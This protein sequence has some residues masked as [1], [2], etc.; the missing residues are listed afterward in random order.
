[1]LSCR[2]AD[3]RR[4]VASGVVSAFKK[5]YGDSWGPRLEHIL[6]NA[7]LAL[8]EVPGTSLLSLQ[9]LLGDTQYRKDL[10]GT[11][12]R[13]GG[14]HLLGEGVRHL[15]APVPGR[16]HRPDPEQGR[17]VP[18]PSRSSGRS[19]GSR[20][21]SLDLRRVMDEGQILIVNLSKGRIG[22]DGST[23][24][25]SLLVTGIQLAAMSRADVPENAAPRLR[26]L[27]G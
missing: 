8:L 7:L 2:E 1:M 21:S 19:S 24:L 9:R 23:L 4:L 16:G 10:T 12:P 5:L 18:E 3:Q 26:P 25:G 20:R 14:P 17:A 15:E 13:S 22:E 11:R 27:R 6:R